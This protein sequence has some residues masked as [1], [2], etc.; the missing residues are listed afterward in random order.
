MYDVMCPRIP[1]MSNFNEETI[2]KLSFGFFSIRFCVCDLFSSFSHKFTESTHIKR[3]Q[4]KI[5]ILTEQ[6]LNTKF[7]TLYF[8]ISYHIIN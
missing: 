1:L 7:H 2:E 4:K 5:S 8:S 6:W 3:K